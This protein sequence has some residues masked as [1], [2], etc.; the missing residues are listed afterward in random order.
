MNN[1]VITGGGN[2]IKVR[3]IIKPVVSIVT[4]LLLT[5]LLS[6]CYVGPGYYG[7]R[8]RGCHRG[9]YRSY[10]YDRPSYNRV[11]ASERAPSRMLMG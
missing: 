5:S 3:N 1:N 2:L 10:E 11:R 8:G 7:C 4:C 6:S 9:Y